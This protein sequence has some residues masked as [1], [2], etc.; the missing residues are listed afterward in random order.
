MSTTLDTIKE[1]LLKARRRLSDETPDYSD[2][3]EDQDA[4]GLDSDSDFGEEGDDEASKW[5][6]E[7]DGG[8]EDPAQESEPNQ[9]EPEEEEIE[10]PVE[11]PQKIAVKPT[12]VKPGVKPAQ[13]KSPVESEIPSDLQ[14]TR[15]ELA[16]MREY[17]RP[18]EQRARDKSKLEAQAHINPHKHHQGRLIEARNTSYADKQKAQRALAESP[19]FQNA[20][21]ITQ[22]EMEQKFHEDWHKQNPDHLANALLTHHEAHKKRADTMERYSQAKDE[23]IRHIAGGGVQP[24]AMSIE[25]GIQHVGGSRDDEDSGP[26]GIQQDKGSAFAS[27]NQEFIQQYM[28]NYDKK[29]KKFSNVSD[30]DT[31]DPEVRADVNT[32]LGDHSALKDPAKKKLVDRFVAKY[33]PQIGKAARHVLSK[34]G[35]TEKANGGE[36]DHGLLHEAGVHALFQAVN[37]YNHDHPSGAKFTTHLNRKMHGL[38]Q[39]ALKAQDEIPSEL[40]A[41]A[42]SFNTKMSAE[43]ASPVKT[44]SPEE[45]Q[46]IQGSLTPPSQ[47]AQEKMSGVKKPSLPAPVA[48]SPKKSLEQIAASHTPDLQDRLK[49]VVAARAPIVRKQGAAMPPKP[50]QPALK[51]NIRYIS[52]NES[53]EE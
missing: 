34:L 51:R 20:D 23:K 14:P 18:W 29:A 15:E 47:I 33:H 12:I 30:L 11:Q 44:Y 43:K 45:I 31:L 38:M 49:R 46:S 4:E 25:E 53:G 13:S 9:A 26:S 36:I 19:E 35:L 21:P 17:T 1:F 39:A 22:M 48:S 40:R 8:N 5:L 52:E 27:G 41:K 6:K 42:K 24:G 16:A 10:R 2:I 32:V 7:N 28:Q 37:D 50:A 3:D